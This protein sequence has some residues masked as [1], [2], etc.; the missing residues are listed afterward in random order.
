MAKFKQFNALEILDFEEN[1]FHLPSH[2]QNYY[3]LVYIYS[4]MGLHH[5]NHTQLS[6]TAGDIFVISPEDEHN[7]IMEEKTRII[8]VKFT[9]DYFSSK[10]HWKLQDYMTNSPESIMSN[11]ILKEVK[12]NF[13]L[14]AKTILLHTIENILI[15]NNTVKNI[16]TS[17]IV[18]YQ[19]LSLF[20]I[21]KE[22]M[23][24][25]SINCSDHLLEKEQL[26]SYIHQ[27]IYEPDMIKIKCI[28]LHFNIATTY[29]SAYFKR[30]FEVSYRKYITDYKLKLIEKR[31]QAGQ[32]TMKQI[33]F[34]FGF[35]DESHLTNYFKK[36]MNMNP[37]DY[38]FQQIL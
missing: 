21:I 24:N 7:F 1:D 19:I 20:G 6:Y 27:H 2:G 8:C 38:K 22:T 35:T 23:I 18:F 12:L 26:I 37:S 14:E 10:D 36:Q 29:F 16:S 25:M 15:Y 9:D 33:A 4:G 34:E 28:A 31:I 30:N 17:P 32:M 3:E 5:I 13:A 11:K